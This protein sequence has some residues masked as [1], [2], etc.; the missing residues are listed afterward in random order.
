MSTKKERIPS[1]HL[2][3]TQKGVWMENDRDVIAVKFDQGKIT[4]IVIE[5]NVMPRPH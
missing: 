1:K 5:M 2:E 3:I 4:R